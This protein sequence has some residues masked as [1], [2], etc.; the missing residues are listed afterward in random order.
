[1]RP[2]SSAPRRSKR[3]RK[4]IPGDEVTDDYP[5]PGRWRPGK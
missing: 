5:V 2:I 1:M 3:T 4:N